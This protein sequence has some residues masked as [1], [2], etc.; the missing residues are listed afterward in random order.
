MAYVPIPLP[1]RVKIQKN[2]ASKVVNDYYVHMCKRHSVRDFSKEPVSIEIIEKI[3]KIIDDKVQ[4][5]DIN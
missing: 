1:N 3:I 4:K 2:K 5:I